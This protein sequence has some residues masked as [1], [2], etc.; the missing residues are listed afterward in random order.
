[1]E[2]FK[3][4]GE[5]SRNLEVKTGGYNSSVFAARN[6]VY[7]ILFIAES[8]SERQ[9]LVSVRSCFHPIQQLDQ[10]PQPR[11]MNPSA[12]VTL[13]VSDSFQNRPQEPLSSIECQN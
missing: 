13:R 8:L 3:P 2:K 7:T 5:I 4:K 10:A 6:K 11:E 12:K 9:H 1:M